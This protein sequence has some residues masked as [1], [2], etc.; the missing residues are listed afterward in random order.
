P[1]SSVG[2]GIPFGIRTNDALPNNRELGRSVHIDQCLSGSRELVKVNRA[3]KQ[4]SRIEGTPRSY[5]ITDDQTDLVT[6]CDL[7]TGG[8]YH[9]RATRADDNRSTRRNKA[10]RP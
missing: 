4:H 5:P 3:M 1:Y 8:S 6:F 7:G 2:R 10:L 9:T